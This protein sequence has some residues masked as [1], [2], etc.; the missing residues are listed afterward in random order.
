MPDLN[1]IELVTAIVEGDK[2]AE[3]VFVEFYF[4]KIKLIVDVR[5]RNREDKQ[6]IID[7]ILIA[8]LVKIREQKYISGENSSLT[9]YVHGIARNVI[10]QYYKDYYSRTEKETQ[11]EEMIFDKHKHSDYG[12]IIFEDKQEQ[13]INQKIWAEAI[14]NL[15]RKYREAIYLKFYK[16]LSIGEISEIM[17][18][19]PQKVSDYLKYAKVLLFKELAKKV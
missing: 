9:K 17:G 12:K 2:A 10:N 3:K 15:K 4:R 8:A 14:S 18:I 11:V 16:D 7:D 6:E 5:M 13:E 19:A 1:E